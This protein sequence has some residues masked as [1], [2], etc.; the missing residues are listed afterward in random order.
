MTSTI[1][2]IGTEITSIISKTNSIPTI[3]EEER[4]NNFLDSIN[5]LKKKL[6]NR[7]EK[8]KKIEKLLTHITWLDLQNKEEEQLLKKVIIDSKKF[9][10]KLLG[11]Y[12]DLKTSLWQKNICRNE[13]TDYKNIIDDF[14][15]SVFEVEQIFF[16]LRN[17][18]EFN[19]LLKSI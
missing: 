18:E 2:N 19:N 15:D 16:S 17:D 12:V 1:S 9:H 5:K 10:K 13:I 7:I 3:S 4:V 11:N 14:E 8:I 6:A